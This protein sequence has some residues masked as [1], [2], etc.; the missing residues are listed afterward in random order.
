MYCESVLWPVIK[1]QRVSCPPLVVGTN[2][3]TLLL[4][5]FD[6]I[7][8]MQTDRFTE[9]VRVFLEEKKGRF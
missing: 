7:T 2:H 4:Q 8:A 1:Q 9:C 5:R 3:N 6:S